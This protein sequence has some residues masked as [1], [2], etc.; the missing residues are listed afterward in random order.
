[1]K[2]PSKRH[3]KI[4]A[5]YYKSPTVFHTYTLNGRTIAKKLNWMFKHITQRTDLNKAD[6]KLVAD[7]DGVRMINRKNG[8][9]LYTQRIGKYFIW[10]EDK[11]PDR[12]HM[13]EDYDFNQ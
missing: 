12:A 3:G 7:Q 10:H 8:A 11:L 13:H 1:M 6:L 2:L 9:R 5:F 4:N